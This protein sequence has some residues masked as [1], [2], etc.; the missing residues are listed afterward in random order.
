M[1]LPAF[2]YTAPRTVAEALAA[3]AA[4]GS[5]AKVLAG[6]QSLIPLLS[7][8]V[9]RPSVVVDIGR[10]D[11]LRYIRVIDGTLRIGALA[12]HRDLERS[13]EVGTLVPMLADAA[14]LI[15]H[16]HIRNRGTIGG[17]LAH[18]DPAAEWPA[19]L[20]ALDATVVVTGPHGE[21]EVSIPELITG[22]LI[23]SLAHDELITEIRAPVP[24]Q[25]HGW[26]FHEFS[27]RSGDFAL[28]S[29]AVLVSPER[30]GARDIRVVVGGAGP[31][32]SRC[33]GAESMLNS[34]AGDDGAFWA[35][36]P[37]AAQAAAREIDVADDHLASAWYRRRLIEVL[38]R[39]ALTEAA[40][41][42]G[43]AGS[44]AGA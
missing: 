15:G 30:R 32:P 2:E 38:V 42:A 19:A 11:A 4:H 27:A 20:L 22:P 33:A 13:R 37:G 41:R 5:D 39:D 14:R 18:A 44:G 23:T 12:R 17:S 9:V 16:T 1:I 31:T 28:A 40:R 7:L 36:I 29:A 26:A 34:A 24:D 8:R 10:I 3:L 35:A 25:G 6:G 43:I 21:R